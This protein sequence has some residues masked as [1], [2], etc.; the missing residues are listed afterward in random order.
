MSCGLAIVST[1]WASIP[2]M[3]DDQ[4]NGFLVDIRDIGGLV[5]Q[6][7]RLLDFPE[8]RKQLGKAA[9]NKYLEKYNEEECNRQFYDCFFRLIPGTKDN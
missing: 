3:I 4:V 7:T 9:R 5:D 6:T 8:L 1:K 2:E